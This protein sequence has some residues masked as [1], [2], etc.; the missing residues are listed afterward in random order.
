MQGGQ[1]AAEGE[2]GV[3]VS[4]QCG[5]VEGVGQVL[6]ERVQEQRVRGDLDEGGVP[7]RRRGG[8]R[9]G[10]PDRRAEIGRPVRGVEVAGT[11]GVVVDGRVD[12][13]GGVGAAPD[14][15]ETGDQF[16][17][18]RLDLGRVPG[19]LDE[20]GAGGAPHGC[21]VFDEPGHGRC[22]TGHGLLPG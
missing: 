4:A 2:G 14:V 12:A 19:A 7:V 20:H 13:Y 10:E 21:E 18:Q 5:Q 9:A 8:Q 1:L 16:G 15:A 11:G 3:V 17:H 22:L 6:G